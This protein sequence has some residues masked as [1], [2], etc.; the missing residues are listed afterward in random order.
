MP[1]CLDAVRDPSKSFGISGQP[2]TVGSSVIGGMVTFCVLALAQMF[3]LSMIS[4]RPNQRAVMMSAKL[5]SVTGV[6]RIPAMGFPRATTGHV[7]ST[8]LDTAAEG[9][10]AIDV[11]EFTK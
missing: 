8:P 5:L 6:Q 4:A 10:T 7:S 2:S 9:N 1:D 3:L 11:S